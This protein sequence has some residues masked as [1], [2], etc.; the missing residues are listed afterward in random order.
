MDFAQVNFGANRSV[1]AVQFTTSDWSRS[2]LRGW[3]TP[4][5][6]GIG[7]TYKVLKRIH[8]NI[9]SVERDLGSEGRNSSSWALVEYEFEGSVYYVRFLLDRNLA[10]R[11]SGHVRGIYVDFQG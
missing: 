5:G 7:T 2:R 6:I 4:E 3:V 10:Q 8:P 11:S 1:D 9:R